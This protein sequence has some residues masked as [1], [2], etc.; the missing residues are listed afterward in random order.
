MDL[1]DG[2]QKRQRQLQVKDLENHRKGQEHIFNP[3]CTSE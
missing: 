1:D 3:F 2:A